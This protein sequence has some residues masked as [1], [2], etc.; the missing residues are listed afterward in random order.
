MN[1]N[2]AIIG[3]TVIGSIL[4]VC[5]T[6][7]AIVGADSSPLVN[8]LTQV[9]LILTAVFSAYAAFKSGRID[10]STEKTAKLVNGHMTA[11]LKTQGVSYPEDT[12]TEIEKET[13]SHD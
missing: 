2:T 6:V 1:K 10:A 13:D 11:L 8:L 4:I 3:A 7:L 12:V 9:P 5:M